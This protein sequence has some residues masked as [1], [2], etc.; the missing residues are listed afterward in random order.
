M[1]VLLS[2]AWQTIWLSIAATRRFTLLRQER[3]RA[4]AAEAIAHDQARRD[5]LTGLNNRRGFVER[6]GPLLADHAQHRHG[7]AGATLALL[8]LDVDRFKAIN[9]SLGHDAGDAVLV[10]IGRRLAR[11]DS[12]RQVVGRL[13]GEEFAILVSG[14]GRFAAHAFAEGV[15]QAIAACE[16]GPAIAGRPVTVSIGLVMARPDDDF[17]SLYRAAD[18]ALYA[19]KHQG[20]NRVVMAHAGAGHPAPKAGM[21]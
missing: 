9:D 4:L 3:D 21:A 1:L 2:A 7:A 11:W 16:F 15:R 19:A 20:R 17:A 8:L 5:S 12:P 6:I 10:A 13:G 14:L 18:A